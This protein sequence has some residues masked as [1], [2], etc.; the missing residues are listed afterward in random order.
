MEREPSTAFYYHEGRWIP[1]ALVLQQT[2]L[3]IKNVEVLYQQ[4][5]FYFYLKHTNVCL[6]NWA[7]QHLHDVTMTLAFFC[8]KR[9]GVASNRP[10]RSLNTSSQHETY[11]GTVDP[12]IP[13]CPYGSRPHLR[14]GFFES[15]RSGYLAKD[16]LW[17][18]IF[19]K[20]AN[21]FY[22]LNP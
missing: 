4:L 18:H 21:K 1:S 12:S 22:F 5:F 17:K 7:Q 8:G 11:F 19:T 2:R 20:V 13:T 3:I 15:I 14:S 16:A 9:E 10:K 6:R